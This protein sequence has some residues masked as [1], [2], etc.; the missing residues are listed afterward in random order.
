MPGGRTRSGRSFSIYL[1]GTYF[2]PKSL[3]GTMELQRR[4]TSESCLA[5]NTII[6]YPPGALGHWQMTYTPSPQPEDSDEW[7]LPFLTLG[8]GPNLPK[9]RAQNLSQRLQRYSVRFKRM[10]IAAKVCS[11]LLRE[12]S[13]SPSLLSP[14][15]A[16]RGEIPPPW[17]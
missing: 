12:G 17:A 15:A 7:L 8:S 10:R 5:E 2:E 9:R 11:S 13:S 3:L 16:S 4:T 1:F 6:D 14:Q